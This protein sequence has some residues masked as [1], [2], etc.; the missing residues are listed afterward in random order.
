MSSSAANAAFFLEDFS[1]ETRRR[2]I[3][4][5]DQVSWDD[6]WDMARLAHRQRKSLVLIDTGVFSLAELE[7]LVEA[8]TTV[9]SYPEAG[10][11]WAEML[12]LKKVAKRTN[13]LVVFALRGIPGAKKTGEDWFDSTR[14][15]GRGGVDL[16]VSGGDNPFKPQELSQ[17]AAD[18]RLGG[19]WFLYYH[20][21]PVEPWLNPLAQ[22]GAWLHLAAEFFRVEDAGYL[23]ELLRL[24]PGK[25][26]RLVF[27]CGEKCPPE[28]K[29]IV[30]TRGG[31]LVYLLP[32]A[33]LG[34][35]KTRRLQPAERGLPFRAFHLH[36]KAMF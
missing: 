17:L 14:Q 36:P 12:L 5:D 30:S 10:R 15:M 23:E 13:S 24:F 22:E 11:S 4:R 6:V 3:I 9:L 21:G 34:N 33:E 7:W 2:I 18:C 28:L 20:H 25:R 35:K 26:P 29:E 8:R 31:F 16:H 1:L 19:A 32:P 27:H